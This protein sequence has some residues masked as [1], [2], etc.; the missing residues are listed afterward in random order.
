LSERQKVTKK[1]VAYAAGSQLHGVGGSHGG[2][3]R[4]G[5]VARSTLLTPCECVA[6]PAITHY[7]TIPMQ[8]VG[9]LLPTASRGRLRLLRRLKMR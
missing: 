8:G 5:V 6:V 4:L 1:R 9:R 2:A 3:C 7:W